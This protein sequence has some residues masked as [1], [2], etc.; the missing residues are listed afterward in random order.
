MTN[1]G[2]VKCLK[3]FIDNAIQYYRACKQKSYT[4]IMYRIN[5]GCDIYPR[6]KNFWDW[7]ADKTITVI[8][9]YVYEMTL[10]DAEEAADMAVEARQR[11]A[12]IDYNCDPY[13][14]YE[15]KYAQAAQ[16]EEQ[17]KEDGWNAEEYVIGLEDVKA[18]FKSN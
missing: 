16:E 7:E 5:M 14:W 12:D 2:Y 10:Y 1:K 15:S 11:L 6:E 3:Y 13:R 17:T 8:D 18:Y 4:G 9:K